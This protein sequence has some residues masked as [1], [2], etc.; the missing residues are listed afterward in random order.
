M[1]IGGLT[2][3]DSLV[4]K[5]ACEAAL[6]TGT[7]LINPGKVFLLDDKPVVPEQE[8]ADSLEMLDQGGYI[9]LSKTMGR[10]FS[11]FQITAYGLDEYA[12]ACI[13]DYQST[14]TAVIAAIVNRQLQDNG[15]I[16][17]ELNQSNILVDLILDRFESYGHLK[18][19]KLNKFCSI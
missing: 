6:Q 7:R 10:G 15:S 4:L 19:S 11:H 16:A 9:K 8:L 2:K 13:P 1:A 12:T 3:I 17:Q 18:Q 5:L 14:V